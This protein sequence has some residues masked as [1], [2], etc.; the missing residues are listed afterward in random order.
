MAGR[1]IVPRSG[2]AHDSLPRRPPADT[3]TTVLLHLQR[4]AGNA[5]VSALV[6]RQSTRPVPMDPRNFSDF[7]SW[8]GVLPSNATDEHAVNET[9]EV[10]KQ[11][12]DLA[13]LVVHLKAD[14]ADVTILLKH[15]YYEAHGKTIKIPARHPRDRK[16]RMF[17]KIGSGVAR[18]DLRAALVNLG[19]VHFQDMRKNARIVNY[20]G[21]SNPH[22]NLKQILDAGLTPGDVLVW[23]KIRGVRGNFSGHIQT[24]QNVLDVGG[25]SYRIEVLQGTLE[26]GKA[27]GEIQTKLLTSFLLTGK[28]SGDGPITFRPGGEETFYGA[29]K[30]VE[31][32]GTVHRGFMPSA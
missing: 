11:L 2:G 13:D 14:C 23:K 19:T 31:S 15:Y 10:K 30:W 18:K 3:P 27:V 17:Y 26:S 5:A 12:P 7:G 28:P 32:G 24:V 8:L 1:Q 4:R 6:Q 16:K 20:Y 9:G 22:K 25:T 21:G 29:G